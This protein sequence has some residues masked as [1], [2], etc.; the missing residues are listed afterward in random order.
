M[1]RCVYTCISIYDDRYNGGYEC[2]IFRTG[3]FPKF[4]MKIWLRQAHWYVAT[5]AN[6]QQNP[7]GAQVWL[8][9]VALGFA[10]F[11]SILFCCILFFSIAFVAVTTSFNIWTS[12]QLD[13][14]ESYM[15][16]KIPNICCYLWTFLCPC[17][18]LSKYIVILMLGTLF[19]LKWHYEDMSSSYSPVESCLIISFPLGDL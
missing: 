6:S 3:A 13:S 19:F 11:N 5:D 14:F 15:M 10:R 9:S 2:C 17:C 4:T 7:G 12:N 8:H 16:C 1:F 18:Q